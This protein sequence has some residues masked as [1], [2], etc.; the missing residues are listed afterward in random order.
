MTRFEIQ[1]ISYQTIDAVT[2]RAL[3]T[4]TGETVAL[5]RFF[6]YGKDEEGGEGLDIQEGKAFASACQRLSQLRH[7][8]LRRTIMGDIDPIDGMPYL[9]TEWLNGE[10]LATV[11]NG[12]LMDP[13][14]IITLTRQA[15]EVCVILSEALQNEAIWIDTKTDSI[16]VCNADTNPTFSFRIC[17]FKWLG[18]QVHQKDLIGIVDMVEELIGWKSKLVSDQAGMGLGG[19]LKIY[20][21]FPQMPLAEAIQRLPSPIENP[22]PLNATTH[23]TIY[24]PLVLA[25]DKQSLFTCRSMIV[26]AISACV[27]VGI[28]AFFYQRNKQRIEDIAKQQA[29]QQELEEQQT[30]LEATN[31]EATSLVAKSSTA[32]N[33]NEINDVNAKAR[34]M[35]EELAKLEEKKKLIEQTKLVTPDDFELFGNMPNGKPISVRGLV[36]S[37]AKP[38]EKKG[39]YI[40]FSDPWDGKQVRAVIYISGFE[41]GIDAEDDI[42]KIETEY[43]NLVG[44]TVLIS[45]TTSKIGK[46]SN[47]SVVRITKKSDIVIEDAQTSTTNRQTR[48]FFSPDDAALIKN[49]APKT[50]VKLRGTLK[51]IRHDDD[52]SA[53]VFWFSSPHDPK[54]IRGLIHKVNFDDAYDIEPL[55]KLINREIVLDGSLM[56]IKD[57]IMLVEVTDLKQI[58]NVSE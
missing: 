50:P 42:K 43:Q 36:K 53:I 48:E 18:T 12:N 39:V 34:K 47:P 7:P 25:G 15:L 27:T 3:D 51:T 17:P 8:I 57:D 54:Q 5:R 2:F 19:L 35:Q 56:K 45:G 33:K 28:I 52:M 24:Q 1:D 49:L 10:S 31:S 38:P 55:E 6:P 11:L 22:A 9:V 29:A 16:I 13:T 37:V 40:S 20:R 14:S 46:Q 41:S 23:Q 30:A 58:T 26:M 44:K 32:E 4:V 21:Q